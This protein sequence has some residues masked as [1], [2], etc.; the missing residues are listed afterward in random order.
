MNH[1]WEKKRLGD[2]CDVIGGSTPKTEVKEFWNGN[3]NWFTPAEIAD[4]KYYSSSE[5]KITTEAVKTSGLTLMP[6]GTVLLTSRAPIGKV[7]ITTEYSYCN[8]GFKNLICRENLYNEYLYHTLIYYN[9]EIEAKGRGVTFKEISKKATESISIPVPPLAVQKRIAS[10]LD[11]IN[12]LIEV[13]RSQLVDLDLL[14]Q[15]LFYEMFGDPITNPKGWKISKVSEILETGSGGTPS[16][17]VDEFW[18]SEDIPWIGSNMCQNKILYETD[19]KFISKLGLENS[20]AKLLEPDTILIALVG[21]TIGKVA[22]LKIPTST[23]QNIGFIKPNKKI[24]NPIFLFYTIQG[25][26][27]LFLEIG[28]GKFKMANLSFIRNLPIIIPPIS[29]QNEFSMRIETIEEQKNCIDSSITDLQTLL[30]SRMDYWYND[31]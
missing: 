27:S 22:L 9:E 14:A 26:Y 11:K 15:S 2:V 10:E 20:T 3:L 30:A 4:A 25:L 18:S 5:R 1:G 7:G 23:N 19:G 21:A 24:I 13:K 16:K 29:L 28:N 17:S 8:Q 31:I 6:P 12:E